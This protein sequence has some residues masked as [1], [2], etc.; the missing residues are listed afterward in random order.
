MTSVKGW[1]A[2]VQ[3]A[4]DATGDPRAMS[5]LRIVLGPITLLHLEP[6]LRLA[7]DGVV[8]SDRFTDPFFNWFPEMSRDLYVSSLWLAAACCGLLTVGA[9]TRAVA[10]YLASFVA[11]NVFLSTTHFSHNRAFLVILLIGVTIVPTGRHFSLDAWISQRWRGGR[12]ESV[13]LWPIWLLRFEVCAVYLASATSKLVDPD[14][15]SGTVLRLRSEQ[16]TELALD[17]GAPGW[18]LDLA[19]DETFQWFFSKAAVLTELAIVALLLRRRTRRAGVVLAIAFHL[20]IEVAFAV[21]VFTWAALAALLL[22]CDP[23]RAEQRRNDED[24]RG[25]A[26]RTGCV[27]DHE[28]IGS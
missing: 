7:A 4:I 20:A 1:R 5:L 23:T 27:M 22:W 15:W 8:Y 3:R 25:T 14:W 28:V 16:S 13:P 18:A 12:V 2:D 11:Y 9:L 17:A 24:S 19:V 26:G 6:F 21:Q 10:G